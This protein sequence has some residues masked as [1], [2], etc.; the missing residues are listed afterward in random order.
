MHTAQCVAALDVSTKESTK[1][2]GAARISRSL[3]CSGE[4]RCRF[5]GGV[6]LVADRARRQLDALPDAAVAALNVLPYSEL[7]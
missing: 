5:I 7:A 1:R 2:S 3:T 6:L 4:L